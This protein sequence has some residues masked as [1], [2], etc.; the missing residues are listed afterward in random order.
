MPKVPPWGGTEMMF[1]KKIDRKKN[2]TVVV[3]DF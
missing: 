1:G 3:I 2:V